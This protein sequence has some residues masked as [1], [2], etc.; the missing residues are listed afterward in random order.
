MKLRMLC[1]CLVAMIL[2]SASAVAEILDWG[3][4]RTSGSVSASASYGNEYDPEGDSS[5]SGQYTTVAGYFDFW[6]ATHVDIEGYANPVGGW[7]RSVAAA[8]ASCRLAG[9]LPVLRHRRHLHL[10]SLR[11]HSS[12]PVHPDL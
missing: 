11:P 12:L 4:G 1:A 3:E 2:F 10:Q 8:S 5:D 9:P 6:Y 7:A